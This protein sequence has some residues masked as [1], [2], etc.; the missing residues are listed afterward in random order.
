MHTK[1]FVLLS[2]IIGFIFP[3]ILLPAHASTPTS[4]II[5]QWVE[6]G[7]NNTIIVRALTTQKTCPVIQFKHH[8][9]NMDIRTAPSTDFPYTLC[10]ATVLPTATKAQIAG[11]KLVLPRHEITKIVL[12]GDTGCSIHKDSD[13][14]ACNNITQW[15][16]AEIAANAAKLKPDLVIH[17][18]DYLYRE[19]QCPKNF[20]G[21]KGSPHGDNWAAWQ[22]DFFQPA[23]PLLHAAPWI[24][25]R[26]NHETCDRGGD[27]WTSLLD[28]FS[29]NQC[30][31]H[32]PV[33]NITIDD[34]TLF[35]LDSAYANDIAALPDDVNRYNQEMQL[36]SNNPAPHKW[37]VTH[38][39]FWFVYDANHIDLELQSHLM[40]TLETSWS[41]VQPNNV[42]AF[43]SGHVHRFQT[44]NFQQPGRPPQMIV[45][46]S[47]TRIN[48]KLGNVHL[49]GITLAGV[50]IS[51]GI[52]LDDFG[53]MTLEKQ[54][55]IWTAQIR[56]PDGN[57]LANCT[58]Q[59]RQFIC[60]ETPLGITTPP[61]K[62]A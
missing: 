15:P 6:I 40:N 28:P 48:A 60:Q 44:I 46:A 22:A 16:F 19:K 56:N 10:Q 29:F 21:C 33:Y 59:Q 54:N 4:P 5:N 14:Q 61:Q 12:I 34:T 18:G 37:I 2:T 35:I 9:L 43:I 36:I 8:Q 50:K 3:F 1:K 13:P 7:Q 55:N 25:V 20:P 41:D 42:D 11:V 53:F 26:G 27:G 39:P 30:Q 47:G 32:E 31:K 23:N 57:I 45:G 51:Q 49:N 52:S 24:F 38:K 62:G 58:L 17:V